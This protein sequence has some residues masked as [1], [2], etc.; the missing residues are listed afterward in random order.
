MALNCVAVSAAL[1]L[2]C[3]ALAFFVLTA[4]A[5]Q[6]NRTTNPRTVSA[7]STGHAVRPQQEVATGW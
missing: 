5:A 2:F 1:L 6:V 7:T 3:G 4:T